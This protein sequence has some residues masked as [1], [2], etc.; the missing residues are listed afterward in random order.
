M[1]TYKD[2]SVYILVIGGDRELREFLT[3]QFADRGYK[4]MTAD[5][6][7]EAIE[8]VQNSKFHVAISD[9]QLP[10]MDGFKTLEAIKKADP[11]IQVIITGGCGNVE[12]ALDALKKGA[13][14]F[15]HKT[16]TIKEL[17]LLVE[18]AYK[19]S[20]EGLSA[21]EKLEMLLETLMD[22]LQSS[23][24]VDEGSFMLM[25][26]DGGL[27]IACSRGLT[28]ETVYSTTLMLGERV[29]GLAAKKGHAFLI[30]GGLENYSEFR[31]IEK[32]RRILSSIVAPIWC[33]RKMIGV[34]NL[35]RT[36][37]SED[38]TEDDLKAVLIFVSQIAQAVQDAKLLSDSE[39]KN[40]EPKSDSK[41]NH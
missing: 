28:E 35:N 19:Y 40:R 26:N 37:N 24:H 18:K 15:L 41:R 4:I 11:K 31:G 21:S 16:M 32:K 29:A 9:F 22:S 14:R 20:R 3:N 33:R 6:G 1:P 2:E 38:F 23:F 25:G 17:L 36:V 7:A 30:K 12:V 27:Y 34:L 39:M 5:N 10:D 8:C 13:Y